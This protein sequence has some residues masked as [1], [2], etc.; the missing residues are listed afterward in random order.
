MI[1]Q[2]GQRALAGT[3]LSILMEETAPL[4][5]ET[6]DATHSAILE[7]IPEEDV[8]V[9]R[10]GVGWKEGIIDELKLPAGSDSMA[11]YTID[12]GEPVVTND[13]RSDAR[14]RVHS[15]LRE[16]AITS[17]L[18]VIIHGSGG[19][20]GVLGI[21]STRKAKLTLDD[22]SFAQAIANVLSMAIERKR[23]EEHL[24]NQQRWLED[25]LDLMPVALLFIEPGTARV[26]FA[27]RVAKE[28]TGSAFPQDKSSDDYN[29]NYY[30]TDSQ[31]KRIADAEMPAVRAAQ[32]ERLDGF[33]IDWHTPK[34]KRSIIASS[35]TIPAIHGHPATAVLVFQDITELKRIEAQL[36][37]ANKLKD[38]FLATV[39]HELRTPLN[40][41]LGWTRMLRGGK[42][43][44]QTATRALETVERNAK[45]QLQIIEDL[46]DVSGIIT[47][48]LRLDVGAV[49]LG[50]VIEA[51]IEAIRP[52]IEAKEIRL[53]VV[54]D[55]R[56]GFVLGDSGR[57]QQI[58]WNLMSNA[59]KFTPKHGRIQV[60]LER[61]NSQVEITV[62]DTGKGISPE[63]LPFVFD[64]FR[65]QDSTMTR[66]HGGLGLGL[67]I[68]RHLVELH[69][70]T[71][72]AGSEG[73]DKGASFKVK[74]PTLIA[75]E[76]VR[77]AAS[78]E[79]LKTL[80]PESQITSELS[81]ALRGI[82]LLLVDDDADARDLLVTILTQCGAE[83]RAV[84][85]AAEALEALQQ[86]QPDLL[87]SDIEMP[88]EDGYSLIRK[89]RSLN[90][91]KGR[92]LP[93]V[94]LTAQA[95]VED[96][97]RAL[98]AGFQS[99]VTKPVNIEELLAVITSLIRPG[100]IS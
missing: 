1:A 19:P 80:A 69:G 3:E 55:P 15:A 17:G 88:G 85:S 45:L 86:W 91:E 35:D 70:G 99:H 37:Q 13:M 100:A 61:V 58:V 42:L 87:L 41:R 57:L 60:S 46:L 47:G 2:L 54:L 76:P 29:A 82:R 5:V 79:R 39:S 10:S 75:Q 7:M 30:C 43:D 89:V 59:A 94:A 51:A 49:Q 12:S 95:R 33:Q 93:A 25:V 27:N 28:I 90:V 11:G 6:L 14:F 16:H 18:N 53:Q 62:S 56:A 8:F 73:E 38:E 20:F 26:T 32:G 9:I 23:G 84:A 31:G 96:R 22:I 77:F 78:G 52:A 68:V 81:T 48:K 98:S 50:P 34:G 4:V 74:L 83:T 24:E 72:S 71:V 97:V 65:Q 66:A 36:Q 40:A 44:E 64:R 92:Q 63:F 21:Y 67:A